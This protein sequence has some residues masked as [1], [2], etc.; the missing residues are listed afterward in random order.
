MTLLQARLLLQFRSPR[1]CQQILLQRHPK[2]ARET[3]PFSKR[4]LFRLFHIAWRYQG[5]RA[6]CLATSVAWQAFLS[7]YGV[8]SQIHVGVRKQSGRL[9][10]HAWCA[11]EDTSENEFCSLEYLK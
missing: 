8:P 2:P 1:I 11:D 3:A 9:E 10:A 7:S 5:K 6:Q 4:H